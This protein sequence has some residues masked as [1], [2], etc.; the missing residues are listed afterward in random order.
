MPKTD[1]KTSKAIVD[2]LIFFKNSKAYFNTIS[3]S[4]ELINTWSWRDKL[5]VLWTLNREG[6]IFLRLKPAVYSLLT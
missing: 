4:R 1:N 2:F 6:K 3:L 5:T